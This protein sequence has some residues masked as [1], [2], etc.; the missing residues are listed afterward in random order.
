MIRYENAELRLYARCYCTASHRR[1][2]RRLT[3][4]LPPALWNVISFGFIFLKNKQLQKLRKKAGNRSYV[5]CCIAHTAESMLHRA[6]PAANTCRGAQL[7]QQKKF[8]VFEPPPRKALPCF[9]HGQPHSRCAARGVAAHQSDHLM[10]PRGRTCMPSCCRACAVVC[11]RCCQAALS[12]AP[13]LHRLPDTLPAP[14]P[15]FSSPL[16]WTQDVLLEAC[17]QGG[18]VQQCDC[19]SRGW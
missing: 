9:P 3:L 6:P 4:R 18:L 14:A 1:R 10:V 15:A 19:M 17:L 11:T 13:W 8:R 12:A 5:R 16:S 2:G 7:M